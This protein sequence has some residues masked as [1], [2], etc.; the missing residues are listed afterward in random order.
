[1]SGLVGEMKEKWMNEL[2]LRENTWSA[3]LQIISST[4][5]SWSVVY[6]CC[7][8]KVERFSRVFVLLSTVLITN[9][10][11]NDGRL[12]RTLCSHYSLRCR[13]F[14]ESFELDLRWNDRFNFQGF[15]V[16]REIESRNLRCEKRNLS[17]AFVEFPVS[18]KISTVSR[19]ELR[20][21]MTSLRIPFSDVT[22]LEKAAEK[23]EK[24]RRFSFQ[25]FAQFLSLLERIV[26]KVDET[27]FHIFTSLF[28]LFSSKTCCFP[29]GFSLSAQNTW[30][31]SSREPVNFP[32]LPRNGFTF[33]P[34]PCISRRKFN[35]HSGEKRELHNE[36]DSKLINHSFYQYYPRCSFRFMVFNSAQ[37][38]VAKNSR[39]I[40]YGTPAP[41]PR[42]RISTFK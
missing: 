20:L 9:W 11:S 35:G 26:L 7:C 30:T 32:K 28:L 41:I 24:R 13:A 2:R 3:V 4:T 22:M 18:I 17:T 16:P 15:R 38:S 31:T 42:R 34:A 21:F 12:Q 23:L 25:C 39:I 33:T 37:S 5:L 27:F 6:V 19:E 8:L 29:V 10:S 40:H 14:I 36:I 1:M